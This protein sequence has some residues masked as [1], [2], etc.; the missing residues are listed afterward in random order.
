LRSNI[1]GRTVNMID[2]RQL[3]SGLVARRVTV[4][5]ATGGNVSG[6]AAQ[7]AT[8][9]IL[10]VFIVGDDPVKLGLVASL[11]RPGGNVTGVTFLAATLAAKQLGLLHELVP[12]AGRIA[13]LVDPSFP[14]TDPFVADV[15]A[16]AAAIG[17]Q[18]EVLQAGTGRDIDTAFAEPRAKAG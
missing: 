5:A 13:V 8:G 12:G 1:G 18:I 11:N 17:K 10:I 2:Y 3:A 15:R 16:A 14:V 6:L 9:T 4:I 7:A